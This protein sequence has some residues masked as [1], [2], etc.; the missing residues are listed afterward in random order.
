MCSST[1]WFD[2]RVEV[3]VGTVN[4][5]LSPLRGGGLGPILMSNPCTSGPVGGERSSERGGTSLS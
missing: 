1:Y 2:L 3:G 5:Y 4:P